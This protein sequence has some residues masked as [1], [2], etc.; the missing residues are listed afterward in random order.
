[1]SKILGL[2]ENGKT[3]YQTISTHG[4]FPKK[5]EE[6]YKSNVV[7][8]NRPVDLY[9]GYHTL[10]AYCDI[11]DY[12]VIG[13]TYS[14]LLRAL[15]VPTNK[16]FGDQVVLTYPNPI[17]VPILKKEFQSIEIDIKEET[18]KSV[19]FEFGRVI[20]VLHFRKKNGAK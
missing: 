5:L 9:A 13:N 2:E 18:G 17:Y 3:I 8:G 10:Y 12:S 1:M 4:K 20:I 11:V 6:A 14:Q 15:E 16:D 19:P 7:H